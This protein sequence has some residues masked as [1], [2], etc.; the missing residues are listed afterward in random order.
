MQLAPP[1]VDRCPDP[2]EGARRGAARWLRHG[3]GLIA[4]GLALVMPLAHAAPAAAAPRW[5]IEAS[6]LNPYGLHEVACPGGEE[7]S[8][9]KCVAVDPFTTSGR[10]LDRQSGLNTYTI[11][12]KN[13][14]GEEVKS[15]SP[16]AVEVEDT[17]PEGLVFA[18]PENQ[19][20]EGEGWRQCRIEGLP[21]A[22]GEQTP[23]LAKC[24]RKPTETQLA[25]GQRTH[26][27]SFTSTSNAGRPT[28]SRTQRR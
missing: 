13:V 28:S 27:S 21:D 3:A 24:A 4:S 11:V 10:K 2:G 25:P 14:G 19:V 20:S 23:R 17:L 6:H 8:A 7:V 22:A 12:V 26:R 1:V 5:A 15:N 18:G 16:Q 9:G